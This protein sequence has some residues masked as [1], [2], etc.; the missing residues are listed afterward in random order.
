MFVD[1]RT[2]DSKAAWMKKTHTADQFSFF[3]FLSIGRCLF[4][5][6]GAHICSSIIVTPPPP[7]FIVCFLF[8]ILFPTYTELSS[9][10]TVQYTQYRR[11]LLNLLLAPYFTVLHFTTIHSFIHSF[12]FLHPHFILLLCSLFVCCLQF[13]VRNEGNRALD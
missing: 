6:D 5:S 2:K 1:W 10:S 13:C 7:P 8:F 11:C 3:L 9:Y 12:P 4:L